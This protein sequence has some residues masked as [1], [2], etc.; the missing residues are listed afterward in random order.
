LDES[1]GVTDTAYCA[2]FIR[3]VHENLN[4]VEELLDILPM[5]GTTTGH[6]IFTEVEACVDRCRLPWD[7]LVSVATDGAPAM[8][9]QKVG[10][11]VLLKDK[12]NRLCLSG[13]LQLYT[14]FCT[15][16]HSVAKVYK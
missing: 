8:C 11:V 7:K 3:G 9:S 2:V 16:K 4:V 13:P 14:A 15:R 5:K 12:R 10:V 6:D 1:T